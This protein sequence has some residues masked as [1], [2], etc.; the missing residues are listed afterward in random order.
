MIGEVNY[1]SLDVTQ[2]GTDLNATLVSAGTGLACTYKGKIGSGNNVVLHAEVCTPKVLTIRCQPHPETG[3]E[4]VRTSD[5]VGSSL[6][7]TF[8]APINVTQ[9]SGSAAHTYNLPGEGA[10]VANHTF[11]NLTRR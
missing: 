4:E 1:N 7:A 11:T 2:T 8:N 5:L 9:I 10:L 6:T 3:L